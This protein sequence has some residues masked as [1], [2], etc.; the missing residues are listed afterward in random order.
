MGFSISEWLLRR[1]IDAHAR[2]SGRPME[3]RRVVNPYHAVSIQPG[4]RACA[5][6]RALQGRRFL[7]TSA[8]SL[9]LPECGTSGCSC[10]YQHHDDRRSQR[11]R[12]VLPHNPFAHKRG[13]RRTGTGRR[14]SD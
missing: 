9:P 1:K 8:P 7:A 10:R 13:E 11:D 14:A 3:H 6:A 12:R 4:P 2:R 5:Q